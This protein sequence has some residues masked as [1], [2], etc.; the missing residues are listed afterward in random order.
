MKKYIGIFCPLIGVNEITEGETSEAFY[1]DTIP[2]TPPA[3]VKCESED[4]HEVKVTWE[5]PLQGIEHLTVENQ[6][7][8]KVYNYQF[9]YQLKKSMLSKHSR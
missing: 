1:F 5:N 7:N 4:P 9:H 3:N 8:V 2:S 6:D